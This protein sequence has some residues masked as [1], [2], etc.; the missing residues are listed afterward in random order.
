MAQH[1]L[2]RWMQCDDCGVTPIAGSR[3]KS[4]M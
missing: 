2:H 1:T 3:Y 4:N